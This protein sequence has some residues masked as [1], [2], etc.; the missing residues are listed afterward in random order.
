MRQDQYER[1]QALGET[2]TEVFLTEGDPRN[3][4]GASTPMAEWSSQQRGDRYWEK[5]NAFATI[6][7]IHRVSGLVTLVQTNSNAGAAGAAVTEEEASLDAEVRAAEAEAKRLMD[8]LAGQG[9]AEFDKRVHG[10]A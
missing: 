5:K 4:T 6:S 1:L 7:L 9:K 2:L 8:R 10:K 3:W